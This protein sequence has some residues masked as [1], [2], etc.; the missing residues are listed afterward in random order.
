MTGKQRERSEK[1]K[2]EMREATDL[3]RKAMDQVLGSRYI[4]L[5]LSDYA[6]AAT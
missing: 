3:T 6:V 2:K 5:Y 1:L 4:A